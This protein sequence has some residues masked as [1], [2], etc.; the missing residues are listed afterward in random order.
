MHGTDPTQGIE[1]CSVVELMYSLEK[2]IAIS[3]NPAM[4]DQLE[5]IAY[6]ALPGDLKH[7]IKGL[8]YYSLVN[9]PKNSNEILGFQQNGNG[10]N[11]VCPSPHSGYGCCRSNFH[12][13]G[14]SNPHISGGSFVFCGSWRWAWWPPACR[15]R[16]IP[17]RTRLH[18]PIATTS[19]TSRASANGASTVKSA[20]RTRPWS[21]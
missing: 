16:T 14:N 21:A 10:Q 13:I 8:R 15:G 12:W 3:G 11:S 7:D 18:P 17:I 6:N 19:R 5:K 9:A 1:L 20:S 4:M 2:M